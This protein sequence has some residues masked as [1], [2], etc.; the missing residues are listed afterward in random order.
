M[1]VKND[2]D[3]LAQTMNHTGKSTFIVTKQFP[4]HKLVMVGLNAVCDVTSLM[5]IPQKSKRKTARNT[6]VPYAEILSKSEQHLLFE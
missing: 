6:L 4:T 3:D 5:A 2:K 1:P